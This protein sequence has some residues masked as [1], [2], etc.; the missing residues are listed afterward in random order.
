MVASSARGK[1]IATVMCEHSEKIA[2]Q[3]GFQAMQFNF[4]ASS[5]RQAVKLW[6]KLGFEIIGRIPKGFNHP[7]QGLVGAL[8]MY[9]WLI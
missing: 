2:L 1:G 6:N 7:K 4:V 3:L 5:N 9:K 8:I